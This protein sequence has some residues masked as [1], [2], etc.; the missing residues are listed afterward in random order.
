M[1]IEQISR[2]DVL[3]ASRECLGLAP[4]AGLLDDEFLSALLRRSAGILCPCSPATIIA[5]VLEALQYLVEDRSAIEERL[6]DLTDKLI[7]TG[8]LL[9]LNQVTTD[10]PDV[11]T[12]WVF[13]APPTFV[14]RP[15]GTVFLLGIVP[16]EVTPLPASLAANVVHEGVVRV[17]VPEPSQ[18]VRHILRDLGWL[19]L[20]ATAWLKTPKQESA[21]QMREFMLRKLQEQPASGAID[22]LMILDPLCDPR[23]YAR[24]WVKAANQTG[25]YVARRPQAYGAPLWGYATLANGSPTRFL[26]FP[27]KGT[28]WRGCDVAWH[29]QMA[30]DDGLGAPQT[31]RRRDTAAGT[32]LDF[33]SPLPLWA[34][35][36]LAVLGRPALREHC[37]FTYWLPSRDVGLEENIL[38]EHLW[39]VPRNTSE[40]GGVG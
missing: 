19:E 33:F 31:Y 39:L 10:D 20:T 18:D 9:E 8:D 40:K 34:T 7:V 15:D 22:D 28:R 37:L 16:D 4:E 29:L 25:N 23:N 21:G 35:R 26:D 3:K 5:S 24:R 32:F 1:V 36:R 30:I 2:E 6:A 12:T 27:L 38:R 11:K 13:A 17:L 14:S